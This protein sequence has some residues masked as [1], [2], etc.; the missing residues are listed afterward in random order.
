MGWVHCKF[1]TPLK[2][3]AKA[4]FPEIPFTLE[5]ELSKIKDKPQAFLR[6]KT[7]REVLIALSEQFFKPLFGVDYFGRLA[8][9]NLKL[10]DGVSDKV[11]FSDCGFLDEVNPVVKHLCPQNVAMVKLQRLGCDYSSDS[12][13]Y[14]EL[15][16]AGLTM[17]VVNRTMSDLQKAAAG[18]DFWSRQ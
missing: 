15:E 18:I 8:V 1:A 12:R 3:A 13:G 10:L 17:T 16:K 9:E 14:L 4:L 5:G 6:K 7:P 11:V 2:S